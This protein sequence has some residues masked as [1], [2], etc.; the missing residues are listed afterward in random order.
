[1]KAV[2][3][4]SER[5]FLKPLSQKHLSLAYVNW[6]NDIEVN[7]YLE[8]G[9]NYTLQLLADFLKEQEQKDILFWAIHLKDSNKHIG[10]I[11][12]DP[13][14]YEMNSGEYGILMGDKANWGKGFA[15]EASNRIIKY[16]FEQLK[17]TEITLGVIENN[18]KAVSLYH[19][20]GFITTKKNEKVGVYKNKLSNSLRMSLDV[21]NF[22]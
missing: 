14:N 8:S 9:G 17:L 15:N 21:R 18:I 10:N 1:M 20:I 22:K 13:I 6:L 7:A 4:E 5:L 19:K 16:C 2:E 11:K 12:I 3:L